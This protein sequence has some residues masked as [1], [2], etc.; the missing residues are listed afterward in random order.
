MKIQEKKE[1][2]GLLEVIV[3]GG[4]V[5]MI[6][7]ALTMAGR[8]AMKMSQTAEKRGQAIYLAQEGL[9][10]IRQGRDTRWIDD[11]G[12]TGQKTEW[13]DIFG[14]DLKSPPELETTSSGCFA[15]GTSSEN[16]FGLR[17]IADVCPEP[18]ETLRE[19][20]DLGGE[21]AARFYRYVIAEKVGDTI[22]K[23]DEINGIEIGADTN[24]NA[25]KFTVKVNWENGK[26]VEVSE[27]LTD[28]KPNY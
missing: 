23:D 17:A 14:S 2:F 24:L 6:L 5:V 21:P 27:I 26:S 12:V 13:S 16:Y 8:A 28:W 19:A 20:I 9:E 4:I 7:A 18:A 1:A 10:I 25:I 3:M 22:L 15:I 11:N